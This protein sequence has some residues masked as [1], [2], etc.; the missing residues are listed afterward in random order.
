MVRPADILPASLAQ[1]G[2]SRVH[3]IWG[4]VLLDIA[5]WL[6]AEDGTA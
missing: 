3:S 1:R 4:Q 5:D 6:A 2:L